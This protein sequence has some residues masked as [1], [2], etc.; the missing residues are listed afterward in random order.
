MEIWNLSFHKKFKAGHCTQY[1]FI[2]EK[3]CGQPTNPFCW[4]NVIEQKQNGKLFLTV[5][6]FKF[7]DNQLEYIF[8]PLVEKNLCLC[9]F[10]HSN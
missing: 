2:I 1:K 8:Q 5:S 3:C 10:L 6:A 9:I 7:V 4:Q